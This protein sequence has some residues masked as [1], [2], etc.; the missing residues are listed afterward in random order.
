MWY[1]EVEAGDTPSVLKHFAWQVGD[2]EVAVRVLMERGVIF[3]SDRP[4][5]VDPA[6]VD[7]GE[8]VRYIFFSTPF[9][10]SGELYEVNPPRGG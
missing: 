7:A 5:T 9:G 1:G 8:T 6:V 4:K 2:I 10:L 3:D